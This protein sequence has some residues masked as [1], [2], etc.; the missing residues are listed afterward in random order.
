[1]KYTKV[2]SIDHLKELVSAENPHYVICLGF[3]RSSKHITLDGDTWYVYNEID[4]TEQELTTEQLL[5]DNYTN[6]GVAIERGAFW[7]EQ[8]VD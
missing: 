3:A 1:M 2:T 8:Y 7:C 5:D 4:D 6:I